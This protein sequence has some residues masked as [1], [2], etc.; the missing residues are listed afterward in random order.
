MGSRSSVS[1]EMTDNVG[2][3]AAAYLVA[4]MLLFSTACGAAGSTPQQGAPQARPASGSGGAA[5]MPQEAAAPTR[6]RGR[7]GGQSCSEGDPGYL[8]S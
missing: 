8:R 2:M 4:T 5:P 6:E 1:L 7:S 3:N